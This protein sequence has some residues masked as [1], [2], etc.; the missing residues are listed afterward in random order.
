MVCTWAHGSDLQCAARAKTRSP[1]AETMLTLPWWL[2][3]WEVLCWMGHRRFVRHWS[4]PPRR[5]ARADPSQIALSADAIEAAFQRSPSMRAARQQDPQVL[6]AAYRHVDALGLRIAGLQPEQGH[7]TRSGGRELNAQRMWGAE[8][9]RS[10]HADEVRRLVS[11]ARAWAPQLGLPVHRW[12][13]DQHDAFGTGSAAAFPGI[14]QRDGVKHVLRAVAKPRRGTERHATVKMRSQG[15]GWRAIER[16]GVPQRQ[17]SVAAAPAVASVTVPL[18]PPPP[19]HPLA[20]D[21]PAAMAPPPDAGEGVL[22]DWRA[23]RGMLQDDQGGPL[24]PPS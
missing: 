14:P 21:V 10:S 2:I 5:G 4:V 22:D 23:V 18:V 19:A 13:A 8:A 6:A 15:R 17:M 9:L 1:Y 12:L 7:A 11:Q 3:G 24:P 20:Q 16:E